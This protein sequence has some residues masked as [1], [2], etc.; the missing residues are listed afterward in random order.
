MAM[1]VGTIW[2][3]LLAAAAVSFGAGDAHAAGECKAQS[4]GVPGPSYVY[5]AVG[6]A[7]IDDAGKTEIAEVA[8]RVKAMYIRSVCLLGSADKQGSVQVNA[9]LS[10]KRAEAVAAALVR[11]GVAADVITVVGKGETFGDS[12]ELFEDNEQDRSVKITLTK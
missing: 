8:N 12:L 3:V 7:K 10:V 2:I 9:A 5:F 6:S 11:E 1:R 4:P